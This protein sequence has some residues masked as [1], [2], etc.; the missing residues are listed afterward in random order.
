MPPEYLGAHL[1]ATRAHTTGRRSELSFRFATALFGSAGIEWNLADAS[2]AELDHVAAWASEYRRLRPLLHSGRV[3][4]ADSDDPA[5]VVHGVVSADRTHAIFSVAMLGTARA[6]LPPAIRM[7][8]LDADRSYRVRRL[9]LGPA[10]RTVQDA[11]P[12][13][14]EAGTIELTGRVLAEVGLAVPLLA[15]ENAVLFELSAV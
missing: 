9:E 4:R 8:G 15:P 13:W 12:P 3:V 5:Q 6:A 14:F 2:D 11:A 1:G 7:P 10:P